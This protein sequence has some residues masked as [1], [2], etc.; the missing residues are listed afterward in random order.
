MLAH[1][2]G[3]AIITKSNVIVRVC[4]N[5]TGS[6]LSYRTL[7]SPSTEMKHFL[8]ARAACHYRFI[9][10]FA[11]YFTNRWIYFQTA[12]RYQ[13]PPTCG[14]SNLRC[15]FTMLFLMWWFGEQNFLLN[16]NCWLLFYIFELHSILIVFFY[17]GFSLPAVTY[18]SLLV[19]I[20]E[21]I[22]DM[23]SYGLD[24]FMQIRSIRL[25]A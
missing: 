23:A 17:V 24:K 9:A 18:F 10:L 7:V 13:N 16:R 8:I 2:T 3:S 11:F 19:N 6:Y 15:R 22:R 21:N 12:F 1:I 20:Y 14:F 25:K 4:T 5:I